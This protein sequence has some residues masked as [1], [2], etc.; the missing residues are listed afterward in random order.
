MDSVPRRASS[1]LISLW[2]DRSERDRPVWRGVLVTPADQRLYFATLAGLTRT[3]VELAGWRD[4]EPDEPP[5][6]APPE[7]PTD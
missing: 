7:R 2:V 5:G 3:L 6:A 4:P 1:Y